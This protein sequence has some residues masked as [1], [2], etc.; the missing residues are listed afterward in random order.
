MTIEV[1]ER[2]GHPSSCS[3]DTE[4]FHTEFK[5]KY[6]ESQ[7]VDLVEISNF[8]SGAHDNRGGGTIWPPVVL[9]S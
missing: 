1:V 9:F 5:R 2:Y 4:A 3:P 8:V 6:L 7:N